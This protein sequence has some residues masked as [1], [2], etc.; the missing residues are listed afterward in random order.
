[1]IRIDLLKNMRFIGRSDTGHSVVMDTSKKVGG[2]ESAPTPMEYVLLGLGGCTG[3]DVMS[4]LR[5]MRQD[6]TGFSIGIE[7][8]KA[9]EHPH[10]YTKIKLIYSVRG[11]D[12]DEKKVIRAIELSQDKYCS[13]SAMLSK[14]AELSWELKLNEDLNEE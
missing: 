13:V 1:M 7:N 10:V 3:M 8:E 12:M 14:T 9:D 11:N 2:E 4:I 5:K 6:V